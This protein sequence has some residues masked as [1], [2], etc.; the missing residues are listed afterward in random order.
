MRLSC[1]RK[2]FKISL[3]IVALDVAVPFTVALNGDVTILAPAVADELV[4]EVGCRNA[5][6]YTCLMRQPSR[7]RC[8]HS[9]GGARMR[10]R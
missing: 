4:V 6:Q 9:R 8:T 2:R 10:C 7:W 1:R 5:R 3:E